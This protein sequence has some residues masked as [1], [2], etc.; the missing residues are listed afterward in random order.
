MVTTV[1][2]FVTIVTVVVVTVIAVVVVVVIVAVLTALVVVVVVIVAIIVVNVVFIV[3]A[4][5]PSALYKFS[6]YRKFPCG[7]TVGYVRIIIGVSSYSFY[8]GKQEFFPISLYSIKFNF[9]SYDAL[10]PK[11]KVNLV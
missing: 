4:I 10:K 9:L 5:I 1:V 11:E 7:S 2:N 6:T 3:L 8:L